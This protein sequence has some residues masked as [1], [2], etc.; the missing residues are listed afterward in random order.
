MSYSDK[1]DQAWWFGL[2]IFL[3]APE[4]WKAGIGCVV[5][6]VASILEWRDFKAEEDAGQPEKLH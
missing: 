3:C 6:I 5:M 4:T 1:C 2:T